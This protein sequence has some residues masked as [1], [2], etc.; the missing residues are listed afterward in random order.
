VPSNSAAGLSHP[1]KRLTPH[2][3][4][5]TCRRTTSTLSA[6]VVRSRVSRTET[7]TRSAGSALRSPGRRY[8]RRTGAL[9]GPAK[10]KKGILCAV[11][12]AIRR[13]NQADAVSKPCHYSSIDACG[14]SWGTGQRGNAQ[15]CSLTDNWRVCVAG[16]KQHPRQIGHGRRIPGASCAV[17]VLHGCTPC[18]RG[19]ARRLN[20]HTK[21][22]R[23]HF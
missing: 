6:K 23:F 21:H 10:N 4:D 17:A 3:E 18:K 15:A 16:P 13:G 8:R 20:L 9:G 12:A 1:S 14:F 22:S 19:R 5:V 11:G 2:R 7:M